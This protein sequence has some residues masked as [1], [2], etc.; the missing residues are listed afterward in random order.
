MKLS[1]IMLAMVA[2]LVT[3]AAFHP[4]PGAIGAARELSPIALVLFVAVL[5]FERCTATMDTAF[6]LSGLSDLPDEGDTQAGE[7]GKRLDELQ[8]QERR[9]RFGG[10]RFQ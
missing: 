2:V 7:L 3:I 4:D 10:G 1:R 9:G 8:A 5:V 6:S